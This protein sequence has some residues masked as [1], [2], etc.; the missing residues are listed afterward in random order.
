MR[1]SNYSRKS[2]LSGQQERAEM[3]LNWHK[4]TINQSRGELNDQNFRLPA[5][6]PKEP[7]KRIKR[8]HDKNEAALH[9]ARVGTG[10]AVMGLKAC[11]A[12][13]YLNGVQE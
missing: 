2:K 6:G 11:A 8:F 10:E 9:L 4:Q 7:H 5:P 13:D 1:R 3:R 12:T